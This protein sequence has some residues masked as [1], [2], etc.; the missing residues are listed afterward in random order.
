MTAFSLVM[1]GKLFF[2]DVVAALRRNLAV[3]LS[4][5]CKKQK[6]KKTN[7]FYYKN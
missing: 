4:L 1:L 6:T 2:L 7:F 5:N 3:S